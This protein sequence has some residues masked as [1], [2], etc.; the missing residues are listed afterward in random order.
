MPLCTCHSRG[1][2]S[3]IGFTFAV[4]ALVGCGTERAVNSDRDL[5]T[6]PASVT[7]AGYEDYETTATEGDGPGEWQPEDQ[8]VNEDESVFLDPAGVNDSDLEI[9][10]CQFTVILEEGDDPADLLEGARPL[11]VTCTAAT[12]SGEPFP[13]GELAWSFDGAPEAGSVETHGVISQVF[14]TAGVHTIALALTVNGITVG[15]YS[16][17]TGRLGE[18]VTVQ[19]VISGRVLDDADN[20]IAGVTVFGTSGGTTA[21]TDS[22]GLFTIHIPL[23]WSGVVVAQHVDYD[24]GLEDMSYSNVTT[25]ITDQDFEGRLQPSDSPSSPVPSSP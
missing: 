14:T 21:V 18:H 15:C 6:L 3:V 24:F 10:D 2:A 19:P 8:T 5:D 4:I 11:T 25:D 7:D 22:N 13:S 17:H 16:S 1:I 20:G 9:P 23:N 12:V